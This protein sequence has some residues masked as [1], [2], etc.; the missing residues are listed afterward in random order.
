MRGQRQTWE[1]DSF[2]GGIDRRHGLWSDYQEA[3]YDLVNAYVTK[4]KKI[5]RRP[6]L[7][8][9]TSGEPLEGLTRV[10]GRLTTIRSMIEA[11]VPSYA[12]GD[13]GTP[14]MMRIGTM[15][16]QPA[17]G[18]PNIA[19]SA[20]TGITWSIPV[21][22]GYI[23]TLYNVDGDSF[24]NI[25]EDHVSTFQDFVAT[26]QYYLKVEVLSTATGAAS[27]PAYTR[28]TSGSIRLHRSVDGH[29][30]DSTVDAA[31]PAVDNEDTSSISA[32]RLY[33]QP[34]LT[35]TFGI[36]NYGQ[37]GIG[38]LILTCVDCMWVSDNGGTSWQGI[39]YADDASIDAIAFSLS[40]FSGYDS[41]AF[42]EGGIYSLAYRNVT[43]EYVVIG[44]S[45][46][47]GNSVIYSDT[48]DTLPSVTVSSTFPAFRRVID[49]EDDSIEWILS[50][51]TYDNRVWRVGMNLAAGEPVT[52]S[53]VFNPAWLT[54]LNI[55]PNNGGII[56]VP[57]VGVAWISRT[58]S[59]TLTVVITDFALNQISSNTFVEASTV[60]NQ[61]YY[62]ENFSYH[63]STLVVATNNLTRYSTDAGV[64]W[65]EIEYDTSTVL[66]GT[67]TPN[68][69]LIMTNDLWSF[70]RPVVPL[71]AVSRTVTNITTITNI[72]GGTEP[73]DA[74]YFDIPPGAD[75]GYEIIDTF[76]FDGNL[77]AWVLH[78]MLGTD[79][80]QQLFLHVW[81][82]EKWQPTYVTDPLLPGSFSPSLVDLVN[83][84]YSQSFRPFLAKGASKLW[85]PTIGGNAQTS[86]TLLPRVWNQRDS[87][88][89]LDEGEWHAF[90]VPEGNELRE[91]VVPIDHTW[92]TDDQRY[93]YY[94]VERAVD[95]EWEILTEVGITP[96]VDYTWQLNADSSRFSGGPNEAVI[97]LLW[98]DADNSGIIRFRAVA[99]ATSVDVLQAP[100]I[101]A[102][103]EASTRIAIGRSQYTHRDGDLITDGGSTENVLTVGKQ[104]L[105][106]VTA[107]PDVIG[108]VWNVT[109]DGFPTGYEREHI[110]FLK[111]VFTPTAGTIL[112]VDY[113]AWNEYATQVGTAAGSG[114]GSVVLTGTG[115]T[116][117]SLSPGNYILVAGSYGTISS[118]ASDTSMTVDFGAGGVLASGDTVTLVTRHTARF[119]NGE[120]IIALAP[121]TTVL[122]EDYALEDR[123]NE[124]TYRIAEIVLHDSGTTGIKGATGFWLVR[125]TLNGQ[126]GDFTTDLD[127]LS[128]TLNILSLPAI[129][130]YSY[131]FEDADQSEWYA[132]RVIAAANKAG[133]NDAVLLNTSSQ[134]ERGEQIT[135]ISHLNGR[136]LIT[137]PSSMQ[138]WLIDENPAAWRLLD[139]LNYGTDNQPTP[140]PLEWYDNVLI[141]SGDTIRE[142]SANGLNNDSLSDSEIGQQML[143]YGAFTVL[144]SVFWPYTGQAIFAVQNADDSIAFRVLDYNKREKVLA[145]SVWTVAGLTGVTAMEHNGPVLTVMNG[146][147][148][149]QFNALST[150]FIDFGD[151][152]GDAYESLA[153]FLY[154][155]MGVPGKYKRFIF[156]D[157]VQ[158]GS[159]LV[160]FRIAP[161]GA[162]V[163]FDVGEAG[164]EYVNIS[165]Q[166][167]TY[168]IARRRMALMSQAIAP[169]LRSQD[170]SG[171]ELQ[172][173]A[174]DFMKL[175]R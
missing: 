114:T 112:S 88:N 94:V 80:P 3:M 15:T 41:I 53:S 162:E 167:T 29:S 168:G 6:P 46:A 171:W 48:Y 86:A 136:Q 128:L 75:A 108:A 52:G 118:I 135:S 36:R 60:P 173:F 14:S 9:L 157:I 81:D 11:T 73:V 25:S 144:A 159:C 78:D 101:A 23:D 58:A 34:Y 44:H 153:Q 55:N 92:L 8:Q 96:V 98:G 83:Q 142:I 45:I 82:S 49:Q 43:G 68:S 133:A 7:E 35:V 4:G 47:N 57:G 20:D 147:E 138:L 166:G 50:A 59:T 151:T 79:Y 155:D 51:S 93:A 111:S 158:T 62:M 91:F 10:G 106:G 33:W 127:A 115:T 146:T 76:V 120:T 124:K 116:W 156:Y 113:E 2:A 169:I 163:S 26:S 17:G 134:D 107:D 1:L 129:T 21:D 63:G 137:Y 161:F 42:I 145:W 85:T 122:A 104:Y 140:S 97:S 99:G 66:E 84:E 119:E 18:A 143:G 87:S 175:R 13:Q 139:S 30:I 28:S 100:V 130:S 105:V 67:I 54:G 126:D 27:N 152:E 69:P 89:I 131:A 39:P 12:T 37:G 22:N 77:C 102:I 150:S 165:I 70:E 170:E 109:D 61:W 38:W 64:T 172:S 65:Q 19:F 31:L 56:P 95:D 40:Q 148:L 164:Q 154:N 24:L 71:A 90:V 160:G 121:G 174:I 123:T 125:V 141:P 5:R 110:R 32:V 16:G 103:D 74:A 72:D 149:Y 132:E 117:T